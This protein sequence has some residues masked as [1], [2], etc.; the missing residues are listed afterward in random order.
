MFE[1]IKTLLPEYCSDKA[2]KIWGFLRFFTKN[3]DGITY[4]T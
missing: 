1:Q 4:I 2:D 3:K